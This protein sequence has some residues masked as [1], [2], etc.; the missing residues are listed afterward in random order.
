M[1]ENIY[2]DKM[3]IP[4]AGREERGLTLPIESAETGRAAAHK[5][6]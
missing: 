1:T 2:Q 5:R 3:I 6:V 4:V